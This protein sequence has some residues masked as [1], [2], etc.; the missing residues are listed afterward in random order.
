MAK[1]IYE[2]RKEIAYETGRAARQFALRNGL[3]HIGVIVVS[4]ERQDRNLYNVLLR[5]DFPES[6]HLRILDFVA[7]NIRDSHS[8]SKTLAI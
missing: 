2:V 6:D 4:P 3:G 5:T 1:T 7:H 8:S